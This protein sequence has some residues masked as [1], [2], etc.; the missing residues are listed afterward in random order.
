[1]YAYF[2]MY[3]TG[4]TSQSMNWK[5]GKDGNVTVMGLDTYYTRIE[6]LGFEMDRVTG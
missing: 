5:N 6:D 1:M 3:M 4:Y 2:S